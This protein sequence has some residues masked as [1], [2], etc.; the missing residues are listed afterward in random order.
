MNE[1]YIAT[2]ALVGAGV[3]IMYLHR[4]I[5]LYKQDVKVLSFVLSTVEEMLKEEKDAEKEGD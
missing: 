5:T 2:A 1:L 4:E 3:Y